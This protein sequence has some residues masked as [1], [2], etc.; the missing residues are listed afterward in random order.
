MLD[1]LEIFVMEEQKSNERQH[2][3]VEGHVVAKFITECMLL[4]NLVH[5][6][7][8]PDEPAQIAEPEEEEDDLQRACLLLE[9]VH[10]L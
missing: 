5:Q 7:L 10:R 2:V 4:E 1:L 8:I 3:E 6:K 9:V